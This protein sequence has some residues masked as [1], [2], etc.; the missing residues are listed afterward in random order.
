MGKQSEDVKILGGNNQTK[1]REERE[2]TQGTKVGEKYIKIFMHFSSMKA[3]GNGVLYHI[4]LI[5]IV[6]F[7]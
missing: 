6:V 2:K 3:G 7:L 4:S 5:V 1:P